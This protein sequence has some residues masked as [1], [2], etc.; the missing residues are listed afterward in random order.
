MKDINR[1]K[2]VLVEKKKTNKWLAEQLGKDPATVSKWCTNSSQPDLVTLRKVAELL[3]VDITDGPLRG[4]TARAVVVVDENNKVLHAQLV[5]EIK[6]E[7]DYDAALAA[8][9]A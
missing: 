3:G 9:G 5:P 6:Q 1:I 7:P 8:L 4:L 2:V